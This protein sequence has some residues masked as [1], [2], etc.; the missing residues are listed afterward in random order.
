M[1]PGKGV[2]LRALFFTDQAV[3]R[4]RNRI[5]SCNVAFTDRWPKRELPVNKGIAAN[6][7]PSSATVQQ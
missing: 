7:H 3:V 2:L 5:Y 6:R 1:I 4:A